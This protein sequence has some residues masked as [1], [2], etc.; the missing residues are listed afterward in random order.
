[1]VFVGEDDVVHSG[2][3]A[4]G[5][6]EAIG[7]QGLDRS[8]VDPGLPRQVEGEGYDQ[9]SPG[10]ID[11]N[12]QLV[13]AVRPLDD[14]H[15][16]SPERQRRAG[17]LQHRLQERVVRRGREEAGRCEECPGDEGVLGPRP[18]DRH[19]PS[20]AEA[21]GLANA[22][23]VGSRGVGPRR[24]HPDRPKMSHLF[25][26]PR[27]AGEHRSERHG[28]RR[29]HPVDVVV[30]AVPQAEDRSCEGPQRVEPSP[31]KREGRR[32][33]SV[34]RAIDVKTPLTGGRQ[35]GRHLRRRRLEEVLRPGRSRAGHAAPGVDQEDRGSDHESRSG[36]EPSRP[37]EAR[38]EREEKGGREAREK[39]RP[40]QRDGSF[41]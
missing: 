2:R 15:L 41:R 31:F 33:S 13:T 14:L 27:Q 38:Q 30:P 24:R 39:E 19:D 36:G 3:N 34:V 35:R 11:A 9:E 37:H 6:E 29:R 28:L 17:P 4:Q 1:M 23:G 22:D 40:E 25:L 21:G 10:R 18:V 26:A 12:A 8:P 5:R 32:P 7:P 16:S 20:A